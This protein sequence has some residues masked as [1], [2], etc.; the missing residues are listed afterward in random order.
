[1]TKG[2]WLGGVE[3]VLVEEGDGVRTM[4]VS[5]RIHSKTPLFWLKFSGNLQRQRR[6]RRVNLKRIAE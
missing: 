5:R 3:N 2:R 1:M 6:K 4:C